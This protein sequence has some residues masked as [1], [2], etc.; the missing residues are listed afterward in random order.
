VRI[1][2]ILSWSSS[3]L[4]FVEKDDAVD[5]SVILIGGSELHKRCGNRY[6][7]SEFNGGDWR[8][9]CLMY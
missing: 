7:R 2:C 6:L 5:L 3:N 4:S 8:V 9:A 1:L